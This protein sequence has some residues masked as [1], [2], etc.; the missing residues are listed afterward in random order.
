M[1]GRLEPVPLRE[2]W[3]HEA[4]DFTSWL[5]DNLDI[6][7]EQ[8]GLEL[9]P[10]ETE[11]SVGTFSA[12][13]LAE[14]GEGRHVVIENQ[15]EKTDHDHL[16]KLITYL[17]NLDAKTAVWITS[18]PRPEHQTAI[19][20][21][22]EVVPEDTSFYLLKVQ[23]FKINE[24]EPAPF[25]SVVAGPSPVLKESGRIKKDLAVNE[26]LRF[27]FFSQLLDKSNQSI[28]L[29]D[30]VSA[31]GYQTWISTGAGKAGISWQYVLRKT[32]A[33]AELVFYSPDEEVNTIRF[34]SLYGHKEEIE[35]K[36]GFSV[37]WDVKENRKLRYIRYWCRIGGLQDNEKWEDIQNDLVEKMKRLSEV[38]GPYLK[39]LS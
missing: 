1:I 28:R 15:L 2:V 13:I 9:T 8:I 37:D 22:N 12:D 16:G 18:D 4:K 27:D 36:L 26:S 35:K 38:L 20:Y 32:D 7:S 34:D 23:A 5:S 30:G 25:F 33:K 21:L 17:S 31:Q 14:D 24:S 3:I 6:L 11:K 29:F 10:I 39:K 19:N